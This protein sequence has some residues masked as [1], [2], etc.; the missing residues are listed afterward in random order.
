MFEGCS[1]AVLV[2]LSGVMY[3]RTEGAEGGEWSI[4]GLR[5]GVRR[6]E[7]GQPSGIMEPRRVKRGDG[8]EHNETFGG[9]AGAADAVNPLRA[10]TR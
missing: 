4:W 3:S 9:G 7:A 10:A 2:P 5:A 6:E 8:D 1:A